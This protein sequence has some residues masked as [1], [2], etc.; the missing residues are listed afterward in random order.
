MRMIVSLFVLLLM[1]LSA[2]S[3]EPPVPTSG[4]WRIYAGVTTTHLSVIDKTFS[5]IPYEGY[6][7]G[8]CAG[9]KWDNGRA[10]HEWDAYFS[11]GTLKTNVNPV[12][13]LTQTYLTAGYT[14]LYHIGPQGMSNPLELKAGGNL[15]LLYASRDYQGFLN[16]TVSNEFAASIGAAL[17]INYVFSGVLEGF[18]LSDKLI[19]PVVSCL[20]Q[21]GFG[22]DNAPEDSR[23]VSYSSLL[24]F[25]NGL[26]L[27][28]NITA[29]QKISIGYTWD[30]YR[31]TVVREV[32][33]AANR[34]A[35]SYHFNL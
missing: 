7:I 27:E 32:K 12:A 13:S 21:P 26:T 23:L 14:H 16:N 25:Y 11:S 34:L 6:N 28:K 35:L 10:S 19:L 4:N 20:R 24:Q 9:L 18:S 33:Q 2:K 17:E 1:D 8:L 29:H 15:H 5:S 22:G 3:Q 31:I 30:F